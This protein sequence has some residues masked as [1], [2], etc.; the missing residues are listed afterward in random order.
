MK[1]NNRYESLVYITGSNSTSTTI[2]W[3]TKKGYMYPQCMLQQDIFAVG[4]ATA[5]DIVYFEDATLSGLNCNL[6][7]DKYKYSEEQ[8]KYVEEFI[9]RADQAITIN[10]F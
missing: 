1:N 3:L 9:K 4:N 2:Q 8:K 7:W 10:D 5:K 6:W